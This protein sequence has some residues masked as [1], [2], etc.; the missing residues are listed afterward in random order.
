M[1]QQSDELTYSDLQ[2]VVDGVIGKIGLKNTI[3]LLRKAIEERPL[4]VLTS[5]GSK[6]KLVSSY[7]VLR[8][9]EVFNLREK[10]FFVSKIQEYKE[11]RMACFHLV[12]K[13]TKATNPM[14]AEQFNTTRRTVLY[15]NRRCIETLSLPEFNRGFVQKFN[16]LENCIIEFMAKLNTIENED[17]EGAA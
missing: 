5:E 13:Y 9:Q 3:Q 6:V 1:Q 10:Q 4:P 8:C 17:T 7:I 15:F 11:G 16:E 12:K 2:S 14:V